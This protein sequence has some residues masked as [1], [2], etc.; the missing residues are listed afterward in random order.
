MRILLNF[1][2]LFFL[3]LSVL[4]GYLL[5]T[6]SRLE[7]I[8]GNYFD[9]QSGVTYSESSVFVFFLLSIVSI[10]FVLIITIALYKKYYK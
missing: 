8:E 7:Y 5:F 3:A 6:R 4:F 9:E 1:I 10:L 2:R